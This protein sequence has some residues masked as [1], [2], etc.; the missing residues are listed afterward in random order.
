M[1]ILLMLFPAAL[2]QSGRTRDDYA[3][4][5]AACKLSACLVGDARAGHHAVAACALALVERAI[6]TDQGSI[7]RGLMQLDL[8]DADGDRR[9]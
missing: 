1:S 8:G 2:R 3:Q 5:S 7:D 9:P 4:A 6:G